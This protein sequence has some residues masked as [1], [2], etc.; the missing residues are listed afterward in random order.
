MNTRSMPASAGLLLLSA[1]LVA[2]CSWS[3]PANPGRNQ[4]LRDPSTA[5]TKTS[6]APT[7]GEGEAESNADDAETVR[8]YINR[9]GRCHIPYPPT[10]VPAA[11]WPFF[12]AK[13]APRAG[14]FGEERERVLT[15]LMANAE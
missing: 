5:W 8:I 3:V 6:T 11:R 14:L 9:C 1:L 12:V 10:H 4:T 2:A 15:W 7:E 13:Y